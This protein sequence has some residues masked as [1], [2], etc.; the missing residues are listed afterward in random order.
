M[1]KQVICICLFF[2]LLI[3]GCNPKVYSACI[4]HPI[5]EIAS[6][7]LL[8]TQYASEKSLY[9]LS[10]DEIPLFIERLLEIE[11]YK[12]FSDPPTEL[13]IL[14]IKITY[15]DGFYDII[16]TDING[17]YDA[18]GNPMSAGWFSVADKTDFIALFSYYIDSTGG[19][20][21]GSV[22]P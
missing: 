1:R 22:V 7:E 10:E 3:C 2:S 19:Q 21:D 14:A 8:D 17:Y 16:G 12:C 5:E 15:N 13:G 9:T 11:F 4:N 18:N 20:G 6:V